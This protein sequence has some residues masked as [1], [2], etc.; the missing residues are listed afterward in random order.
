MPTL[1]SLLR[2]SSLGAQCTLAMTVLTRNTW[3]VCY[4][5]DVVERCGQ[6]CVWLSYFMEAP[7]WVLILSN[8]AALIDN[9]QYFSFSSWVLLGVVYA[10]CHAVAPH[11]GVPRPPEY[12]PAAHGCTASEYAV[13]DA[14]FVATMAYALAVLYGVLYDRRHRQRYLVKHRLL[15]VLVALSVALY[16]V[17][18]L[19]TRYF[20]PWH[21]AVNL[22]LVL[23][24]A[25][26]FMFVYWAVVGSVFGA[27]H[28]STMQRLF[29]SDRTLFTRPLGR[30]AG[31]Q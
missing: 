25:T 6:L 26:L 10:S 15:S 18:T 2:S 8:A 27:E 5:A 30:A 31:R 29:G 22:A 1:S 7:H 23:V 28:R 12:S 9:D 3:V 19:T 4:D 24:C 16:V 13:P 11:V 14:M 17:A 21:L 20:L